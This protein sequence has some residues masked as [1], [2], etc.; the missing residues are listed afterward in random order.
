MNSRLPKIIILGAV[1]VLGVI[2]CINPI[3][4]NEQ[5]LQHLGT[6]ILLLI[7]INDLRSNK[8]TV[9][10]FA[11]VCLFIMI[12][13]VGARYIYSYVPYNNWLNTIFHIDINE[14][15]ATKRNHYDRFV[16]LFFG[17]LAFPYLFELIWKKENLSKFFKLL[18]VW[19]FIQT[20]SVFYELFEWSL[21]IV[22]SENAADNYNGQQGDMWDAQ[23]DM[24]LAMLGSAIVFI[25]YLFRKDKSKIT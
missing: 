14:I 18:I 6:I 7:P 16:H 5:I 1:L 12:H 2:T 22:M 25:I 8:L 17:I 19:T 20:F 13:I 24:A 21:T 15:F 11:C 4:P 23:K 3:Y 9:P 10:T